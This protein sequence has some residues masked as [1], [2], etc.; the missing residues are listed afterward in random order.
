MFYSAEFP[1]KIINSLK[2]HI[3]L[4]YIQ[5]SSFYFTENTIHILYKNHTVNGVYRNNYHLF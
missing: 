2:T 3:Y 4:N 1:E 5:I